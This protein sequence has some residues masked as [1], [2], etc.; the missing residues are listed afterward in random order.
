MF[1]GAQD[2]HDLT[3]HLFDESEALTNPYLARG[4][5]DILTL[6]LQLS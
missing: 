3:R 4:D 6:P 2:Y 1:G 5:M